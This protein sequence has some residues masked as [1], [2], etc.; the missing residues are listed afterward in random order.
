MT[1]RQLKEAIEAALESN[2]GYGDEPVVGSVTGWLDGQ[3]V[4]SNFQVNG[5]RV[6][7]HYTGSGPCLLQVELHVESSR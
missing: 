7:E 4:V 3:Q 5:L 1:L 2:V 6:T